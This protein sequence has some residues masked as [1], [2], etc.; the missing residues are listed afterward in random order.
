[1][2]DV[3][4]GG[5]FAD[6]TDELA[7]EDCGI[8]NKMRYFQLRAKLGTRYDTFPS[9]PPTFQVLEDFFNQ[10]VIV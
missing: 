7:A 1:M 4:P 3:F 8:L 5:V 10:S 9:A 2:G 6:M